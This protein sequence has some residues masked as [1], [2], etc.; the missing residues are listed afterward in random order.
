MKNT[1][2][3]AGYIVQDR[4]CHAIAAIG[5]T[6]EE[7]RAEALKWVGPWEDRNG[8]TVSEDHPTFGFDA[9]YITHP[10]TAALLQQVREE[11]GA[12]GWDI[13]DGIACTIK[14]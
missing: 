2:K 10:A 8:N 6:A 12:I 13:I 9:N 5:A 7:A 11:G 1:I 4:E 3:V 14:S